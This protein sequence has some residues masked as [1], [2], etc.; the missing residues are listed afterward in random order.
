[1]K[2][3][4]TMTV[5]VMLA[6]I[7][8]AG[9]KYGKEAL[10]AEKAFLLDPDSPKLYTMA[11]ATEVHK[12]TGKPILCWMGAH[13][14]ADLNARKLSQELKD[15]TIQAS[16]ASDPDD[17][18]YDQFNP[19]VK[20]DSSQYANGGKTYFIRAASFKFADEKFGSTPISKEETTAYKI[21]KLFE[22][23]EQPDGKD[24]FAGK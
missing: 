23:K 6:L 24:P 19:R 2:T 22:G 5:L 13:V 1:M 16:M 7:G 8:S 4:L 17:K 14:F 3:L 10:D 11:E 12:R 18:R 15:T 21:L 9:E 20:F